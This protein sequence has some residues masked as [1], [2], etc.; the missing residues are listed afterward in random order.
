MS[1]EPTTLSLSSMDFYASPESFRQ[2]LI[3]I[4]RVQ[5]VAAWIVLKSS[6][7]FN[8][9][10]ALFTAR[11]NQIITLTYACVK[12]SSRSYLVSGHAYFAYF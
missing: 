8:A 10:R 9:R 7:V 5:E 11:I 2:K 4:E 6:I 12:I 1:V 3:E